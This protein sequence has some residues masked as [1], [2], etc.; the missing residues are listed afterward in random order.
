[1]KEIV[2]LQ[3]KVE[4]DRMMDVYREENP[5][6]VLEIGTFQ[7][8]TLREWLKTSPDVVVCIDWVLHDVEMA[9]PDDY[10][11]PLWKKW[12]KSA[13]STLVVLE[14]RSEDPAIAAQAEEFAPFDWLFIDADHRYEAVK[15]DYEMYRP[16]VRPGGVVGFHDLTKYVEN[17]GVGILWSELT[18]D[19][20]V[21]SVEIYDPGVGKGDWGGIGL[22]WV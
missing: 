7:G 11:V 20:G 22:L 3:R 12:A 15:S 9:D 21:R 6:R 2:T 4:L 8:G 17:C 10:F 5:R 16:M 13:G 19:P 1:M 14:G 18:A